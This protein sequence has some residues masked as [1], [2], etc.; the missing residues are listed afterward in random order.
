MS[1]EHAYSML[2]VLKATL[3]HAQKPHILPKPADKKDNQ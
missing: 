3:E 2:E 1:K